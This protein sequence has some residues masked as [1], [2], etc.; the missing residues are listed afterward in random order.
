MKLKNPRLT[1]GVVIL[2]SLMIIGA[3]LFSVYKNLGGF[4]KVE[5][6]ELEPIKRT[7]VGRHFFTRYTDKA[8]EDQFMRCRELIATNQISGDLMIVTYQNDSIEGDEIDQ[9]IGIGLKEDVAEIPVD[10]D[11]VEFTSNTRYAVFLS[12]HPM[13]RPTPEE[14]EGRMWAKAQEDGLE[15]EDYFFEIHYQDNSM[16]L[17]GWIK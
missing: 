16:S 12:M 2:I 1:Y 11:I 10:F 3:T 6:Y 5:V 14:L 15:L 13:V 9:F 4:D 8:L 17:E 7:L